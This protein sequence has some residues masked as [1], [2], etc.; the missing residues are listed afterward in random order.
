MDN[1]LLDGY[2][3]CGR[4]NAAIRA[5]RSA[6][7]FALAHNLDEQRV[8]DAAA[9]KSVHTDVANALGLFK[10]WRYP[11]LS[12]PSVLATPKQIQEKLNTFIRSC[13]T[14]SVAAHKIG[15]SKQHLSN[16]QNTARGFGETCLRYFGYGKPVARYVPMDA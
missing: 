3:F 16:I 11:L 7:R 10:V 1:V 5:H 6:V 8:R 13:G 12:D 4:L 9:G 15:V 2:S 14:Q